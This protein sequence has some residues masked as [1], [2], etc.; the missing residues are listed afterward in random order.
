MSAARKLRELIESEADLV[1][2]SST[3]TPKVVDALVDAGLFRLL[4]PRELGGMEAD[5]AT[6]VDVCEERVPAP[7]EG[8]HL[9]APACSSGA[10][11]IV[12]SLRLSR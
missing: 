7:R 9:S 3:M 8:Q 11:P 2:Q 6:I 10:R 12:R 5:P 4:V 1:E